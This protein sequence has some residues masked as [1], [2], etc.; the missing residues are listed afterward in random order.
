MRAFLWN[1]CINWPVLAFIHI[2]EN[3]SIANIAQ[4]LFGFR[5][6]LRR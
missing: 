6:L 4:Q 2:L 5:P 1:A 3:R